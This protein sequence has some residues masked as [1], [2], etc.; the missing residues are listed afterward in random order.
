MWAVQ[1][2]DL[3]NQQKN[4]EM[5]TKE[6]LIYN[7][8]GDFEWNFSHAQTPVVDVLDDCLR[9]YYSSRNKNGKANI[10]FIEVDK[11]NP[12]K[13]LYVHDKPILDFGNIGCFDDSGLMPTCIINVGNEKY[14][15]YIGW[16]LRQTVPYHNAIGL[17]VSIDGGRSFTKP[18]KGPIITT[19]HIEPFFSGTAFVI[20]ENGVFKMWYL[21]CI[22]WE[23]IDN[24]AEP[25][26][27]LK[28]A[29]SNDGINWNQTGKI[30]I[31][32]LS[33][34]GGL[35]SATVIK[36]LEK[37][38][39]WYCYRGANNYRNDKSNSYRIGYAESIDGI[40]WVRIDDKC[41]ISVSE[42]G[43]DTEMICYPYVIK[44][45]KLQLFYNGNGFGKT[46]F[47]Y[48]IENN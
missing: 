31:E 23:I 14:L 46:G 25:F 36:R 5:W 3:I 42:F 29:E 40:N 38:Q 10:S 30:A 4:F 19:N 2:E 41:G 6:G 32:L 17:A 21:S 7:V 15:Y 28:Y 9:I 39:M 11:R 44:N 34:E 18:F 22:K 37:Y 43:W 47:G 35:A 20:R 16:S 45:E 24:K 48:A 27:N 8:N 12:K 26:Y 33:D 1:E 13:I